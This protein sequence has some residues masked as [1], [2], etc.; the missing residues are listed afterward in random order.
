MLDPVSLQAVIAWMSLPGAGERALGAVMDHARE[1]RLPLAALW[2]LRAGDLARLLPLA[3]R[4]AAAL[5]ERREA[6]W[7][8]AGALAG[9]IGRWGVEALTPDDPEY[10]AP[11]RAA[12]RGWPVVFAWGALEVAREPLVAVVSSRDADADATAWT[13]RLADALARRDL[14][15]VS[16]AN[17]ETYQAV[18]VAA[19]RHGAATALVLDRGL[20]TLFPSGPAQE[21]VPGARIWDE[22]L[23]AETQ[24][25]LSPFGLRD[26]WTPR[27]GPRRDA[28]IFDLAHAVVAI[29]VRPGGQMERECRRAA[30]RG[31]PLFALD[32][33]PATPE[34]TRAL[35]ETAPGARRLS[36]GPRT[37]AADLADAVAGALP[38]PAAR[39]P[40]RAG[41]ADGSEA[42]EEAR[43]E[44][45]P[46]L[47]GAARA[48]CP[49]QLPERAGVV[50]ARGPLAQAARQ[51][52]L[53]HSL[54]RGEGAGDLDLVLG[55]PAAPALLLEMAAR[56]RPAGVLLALVPADWLYGDRPAGTRAQLLRHGDAQAVVQLPRG[57][58]SGRSEAILIFRRRAPG[59]LQASSPARFFAPEREITTRHQRRRYLAETLALL[60]RL[61]GLAEAGG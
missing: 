51:T 8:Q 13:D 53:A 27:S 14:P 5:E 10:P 52:A 32:R 42:D 39:A 33:G 25:L 45:R 44:A 1:A 57:A 2:R 6:L 56:L 41:R 55:E 40:S 58:G 24:L 4:T 11:L 12:G 35:W 60:A 43:R 29:H 3:G 18:A 21:P 19:K 26:G 61:E 54:A 16:S 31:T 17:K 46:F 23:D 38:A 36:V 30:G 22:S 59:E 49:L 20:V 47:V 50:P 9:E 28:M 34:G 48:L 37:S 15:L 7:E